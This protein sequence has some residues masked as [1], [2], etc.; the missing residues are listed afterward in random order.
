MSLELETSRLILRPWSPE[1]ASA[2]LAI[3]GDPE[4][5]R[6]LDIDDRLADLDAA[7]RSV[8]RARS[9][10]GDGAT[11]R[12]ATVEKTTDEIIAGCGLHPYEDGAGV[13]LVLHLAR[14][15]WGKGY[16]T[17][18]GQACVECAFAVLEEPRVVA[19]TH[20]ANHA[21]QRVLE[22]LGFTLIGP[23]PTYPDEQILVRTPI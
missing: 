5:T 2:A 16:A 7:A 10:H 18:A 12:W 9:R 19:V 8:E 23:H 3:W 21:S 1:D 11:R 17:E 15:A 20:N 22:K 14:R 13:E 4:V 6:H